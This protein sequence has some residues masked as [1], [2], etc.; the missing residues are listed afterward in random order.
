[1]LFA[2][3]M[4]NFSLQKCLSTG[5]T[6]Q[7]LSFFHAHL[8]TH[9]ADSANSTFETFRSELKLDLLILLFVIDL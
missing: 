4:C 5:G 3:T 1:M 9:E 8:S 7:G 2:A 6:T